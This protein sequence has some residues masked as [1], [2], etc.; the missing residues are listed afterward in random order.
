MLPGPFSRRH[1]LL[2]LATLP[3]WPGK[4][5][6]APAAALLGCG[7][8]AAGD[9]V[10]GLDATGDILWRQAL[11]GR[12]HGMA[13][14]PD[15]RF[16][17]IAARR[18]GRWLLRIDL[19]Q[20]QT[21]PQLW[22]CDDLAYGGHVVF[23]DQQ[24]AALTASDAEGNGRIA[25]L[26]ADSGKRIALWSTAGID[27][28][29]LLPQPGGILALANGGDA[30]EASCLVRLDSATGGILSRIEAP[31]RLQRLSLRHMAALPDGSIAVAAQDR[32]APEPG[33]PLLVLWQPD[34]RLHWV[35]LGEVQ[36]DLRGYCG[37]IAAHDAQLCLTSPQGGI[38]L[39]H[40]DTGQVRAADL[41]GVA[42]LGQG[43]AFSGGRGDL[44]LPDGRR[45]L[46]AV[47]WDNHLTA[48]RSL[49]G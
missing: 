42:P 32:G 37:A 16:A 3:L 27:P 19:R 40:P 21:E 43:F 33:I 13:V 45:R 36:G 46:H 14:A 26:N 5:E 39:L 17:L 25:L 22:P 11:P 44:I 29:E 24:H 48:C 12:G 20:P 15:G 35:N 2:G 49:N 8:D 6:A 18:P 4:A 10:F 41:C 47:A 38:A 31:A 34:E 9:A 28:H 1:L 30:A 7:R 23:L